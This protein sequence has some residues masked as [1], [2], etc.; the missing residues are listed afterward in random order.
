MELKI[1]PERKYSCAK[2]S[3][4][5]SWVPT[6]WLALLIP[7]GGVGCE[8]GLVVSYDR[9]MPSASVEVAPATSMA[10]SHSPL[11][12]TRRTEHSSRRRACQSQNH[13]PT[14]EW[15]A[16]GADGA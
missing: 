14:A 15:K 4:L 11:P 6:I 3:L 5:A 7:E 10:H 1:P 16:C 12:V 8:A 9:V 13:G 2:V